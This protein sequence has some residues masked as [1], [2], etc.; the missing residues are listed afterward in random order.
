MG[1]V[2][3]GRTIDAVVHRMTRLLDELPAPLAARRAFLATYLRTT[4]AVAKAIDDASFEDPAWV[5]A[6]DVAFA[7]LYLDA[8]EADLSPDRRAPRPWALA[9]AAPP[10]TA[11]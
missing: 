3:G 4:Q 7:D 2:A 6:W 10:S 11:C 8:L 9:L 1:D 5:E